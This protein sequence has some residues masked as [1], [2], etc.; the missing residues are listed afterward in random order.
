MP[1]KDIIHDAVKNALIRDGWTITADPFIIKY[2][3]L[4]LAADMAAERPLAAERDGEKI[5]VE[6]KS[7]LGASPIRELETALGQYEMY[8]AFLDET[9][10]DRQLFLAISQTAYEDLFQRNSIQ[11][12]VNRFQVSLIVVDID[13]EE[14]V[15]WTS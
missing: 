7:F 11:L 1:A 5:A 12:I 3:D 15:K 2:E 14:V 9:E 13:S 4:T 8:R 6:V 10:P